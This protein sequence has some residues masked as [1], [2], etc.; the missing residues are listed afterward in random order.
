MISRGRHL[1]VDSTARRVLRLAAP[2]GQVALV[3]AAL[4]VIGLPRATDYEW[5]TVVTGS[6]RP[7]IHPGDV[8]LAAPPDGPP[9]VGEVVLFRD[10]LE[11]DRDVVH[12]VVGFTADGE[13]VTRGDANNGVDPWTLST[14]DLSG[15]VVFQ[16]PRVGF[17]V[18]AMSSKAGIVIFLVVPSLA[19][20]A[21]ETRVWYRFIRYGKEAFEEAAR[22]RHLGQR[23]AA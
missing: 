6:M 22:G 23:A 13:M 21:A 5:R 2:V 11:G 14:L 18:D 7:A 19:I 10:P 3:L 16:V 17:V 4:V 9:E 1:R 20:M 15:R 12:R 8:V